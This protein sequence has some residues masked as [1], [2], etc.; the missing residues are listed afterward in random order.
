MGKDFLISKPQIR[1]DLPMPPRLFT[2]NLWWMVFVL[3]NERKLVKINY[4]MDNTKEEKPKVICN[5]Q[6]NLSL[7]LNCMIIK[8]S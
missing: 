8:V 3:P 2:P 6:N 5:E 4:S 7:I 1:N